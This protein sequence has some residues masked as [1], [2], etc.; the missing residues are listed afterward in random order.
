MGLL[1]GLIGGVGGLLGLGGD[2]PVLKR[3]AIDP[4]ATYAA[5]KETERGNQ[6]ANDFA[7]QATKDNGQAA[8]QIASP[9]ETGISEG[10]M[11]SASNPQISDALHAR[12]QRSFG[13]DLNKIQR[14][15]QVQGLQTKIGAQQRAHTM[16][17]NIQ[18]AVAAQD[19]A[20]ADYQREADSARSQALGSVLGGIGSQIGSAIGKMKPASQVAP[21]ATASG[22]G[23]PSMVP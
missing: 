10:A 5:G 21:P 3:T 9:T 17:M 7:N 16:N 1:G 18:R 8:S 20:Q 14:S 6:S 4:D 23:R 22:G 19:Q 11:G 13:S 2:D 12:A 15:A